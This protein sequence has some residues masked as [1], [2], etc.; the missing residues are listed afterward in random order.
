[1][2]SFILGQYVPVDSYVHRMDSRAKL[3]FIFLFVITV[4]LSNSSTA[5]IVIGLFANMAVFL[6]RVPFKFIIN[7]LKPVWLLIAFTLFVH[8]FFTKGGAV[9]IDTKWFDIHY[10]GLIQG[11]V[12]SIRFILLITVTIL[13]TLTT[14]PMEITDGLEKLLSPLKKVGIPASELALM[15]SI[16]LRFIP[17]LIQEVEKITKAQASRGVSFIDGNIKQRGRAFISLIIPL[18]MS[19]FR[20]A[21]EMATAMET[22]GYRGGDHRT[23]LRQLIWKQSDTM[24]LVVVFILLVVIVLLRI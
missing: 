5:F 24:A 8:I 6:S 2:S 12:L 4:F 22:R 19:A 14:T 13:L 20:R 9:V 7:G 21:D 23:K 17:T 11:L 15:M 18:F 3:L 16:S 10:N 1:M